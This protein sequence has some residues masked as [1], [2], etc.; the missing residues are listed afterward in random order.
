VNVVEVRPG[1]PT[2]LYKV[3]ESLGRQHRYRSAAPLDEGVRCDSRAVAKMADA[4]ARD[5]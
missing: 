1:L 4:G 2:D 3:A 5:Y